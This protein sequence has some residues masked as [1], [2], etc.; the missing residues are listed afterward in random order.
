MAR[1]DDLPLPPTVEAAEEQLRRHVAAR[2]RI[3]GKMETLETQLDAG[4]GG[5]RDWVA[6]NSLERT[7]RTAE[8]DVVRSEWAAAELQRKTPT[9]LS[10]DEYRAELRMAAEAMAEPHLRVL[11]DVWLCR[12]QM[13]AQ[14]LDEA[15]RARIPAVLPSV[16]EAA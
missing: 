7:L 4:E 10:E 11:V 13:M 15:L 5:G 2:D 14:P 12:H 8:Q 3:T 9:D 1:G 6:Y 16:V